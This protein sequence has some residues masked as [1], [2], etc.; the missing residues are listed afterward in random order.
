MSNNNSNLHKDPLIET[1][2][3]GPYLELF[4]RYPQPGWV[5]WGHEAQLDGQVPRGLQVLAE[6]SPESFRCVR[7]GAWPAMYRCDEGR[8]C[9]DCDHQRRLEVGAR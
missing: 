4:A 9:H 5:S 8:L 2:S 1:C 6:G 7:C 3:P